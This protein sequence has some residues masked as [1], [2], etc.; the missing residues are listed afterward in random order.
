METLEK[1][2]AEAHADREK[3]WAEKTQLEVENW[4][5]T[6]QLGDAMD[7]EESKALGPSVYCFHIL[8]L[9]LLTIT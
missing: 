2:L 4:E 5:L 1:I 9:P 6:E 8:N 3:L 7:H